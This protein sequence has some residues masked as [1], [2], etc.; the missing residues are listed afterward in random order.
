MSPLFHTNIVKHNATEVTNICNNSRFKL[1][2]N[3][4][5]LAGRDETNAIGK[6]L[7]SAFLKA[8]V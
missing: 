2:P 5:I 3:K 1:G 8:P 6:K 7:N 4:S